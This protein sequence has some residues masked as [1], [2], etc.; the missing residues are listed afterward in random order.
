[1]RTSLYVAVVLVCLFAIAIALTWPA[2]S[3]VP[4]LVYGQF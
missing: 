1:M 3:I 4:N 2:L